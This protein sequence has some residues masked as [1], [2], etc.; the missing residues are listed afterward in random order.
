M[1][2][3]PI[4]NKKEQVELSENKMA[5]INNTQQTFISMLLSNKKLT[6]TQREKLTSLMIR[7]LGLNNVVP[8]DESTVTKS[9]L[10][11]EDY[12]SPKDV[13]EFLVEYNQDPILKYTCHPIDDMNVIEEIV[14]DTTNQ[15]YSVESH[16]HLISTSFKRLRERYNPKITGKYLDSKVITLMKVYID[17]S[18][19]KKVETPWSSLKIKYNWHSPE[20]W[21]WSR[22]NPGIVANPGENIAE[23]LCNEGYILPSPIISNLT[24]KKLKTFGDIVLYYKS[25]FHIKRDDSLR[26]KILYV[27]KNGYQTG[28]QNSHPWVERVNLTIGKFDDNIE[29]FTSVDK[30]LQAF[31]AIMRICVDV[32]KKF[33]TEIPHIEVEFYREIDTKR[34]CFAIHHFNTEYR[35]SLND[36]ISRI[37]DQQTNL[38]KNQIDGI[39]DLYIQADFGNKEY[40]ELNL[41]DGKPREG[42]PI[43]KMQGVKYILK[44]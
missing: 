31:V 3:L 33:S 14:K 18:T 1:K 36:A 2:K 42:K 6:Q 37:G 34:V 26:K 28:D 13:M 32:Q 5:K 15:K 35:K 9:N 39:C 30:L 19:L 41:W 11:P 20:L 8:E 24:G 23:Y 38:I 4:I 16:Y 29:L 22:K 10:S 44:Y 7:D 12:H 40:A 25:L 27:Y 17:G 43:E 21:E